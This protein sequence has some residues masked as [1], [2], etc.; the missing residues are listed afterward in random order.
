MMI[1]QKTKYALKALIYLAKYYGEGPILI[2]HLAQQEKIPKKFLELILLELKNFG[3]LRSK[4]GRGGGYYL[5][6]PPDTITLGQIIR[7]LDGPLAPIPCVSATAY[8]RC[9][10]C[11]DELACGLRLVMQE[12]RDCTAKILDNT[13]LQDVLDQMDSCNSNQLNSQFYQI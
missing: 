6:R 13:S 8:E 12:V 5:G 11:H 1:S 9:E 3:F 2:S 10:E 7:I 4:K